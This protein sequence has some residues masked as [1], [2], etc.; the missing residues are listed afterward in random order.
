MLQIRTLEQVL[1]EDVFD[2]CVLNLTEVTTLG[3]QVLCL[4]SKAGG[5]AMHVL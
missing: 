1:H 5:Q 4:A 3:T 2:G